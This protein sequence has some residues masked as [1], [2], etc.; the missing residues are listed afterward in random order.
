MVPFS[1]FIFKSL[2]SARFSRLFK[3]TGSLPLFRLAFLIHQRRVKQPR[4]GHSLTLFIDFMVP[5]IPLFLFAG[6]PKPAY[7]GKDRAGSGF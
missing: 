1:R 5:A 4:A 3:I 7:T 6:Q 2:S